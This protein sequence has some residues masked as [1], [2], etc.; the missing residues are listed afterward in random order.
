[1]EKG[2]G[3][4]SL[5]HCL[6][7]SWH[8]FRFLDATAVSTH[9]NEYFED[10]GINFDH[11]VFVIHCPLESWHVF[12]FFDDT[13][14][15]TCRPGSSPAG[16]NDGPGRPRH[17][18]ANMIQ[19]SFYW[20]VYCCAMNNIL[21]FF[22]NFFTLLRKHVREARSYYSTPPQHRKTLKLA[23]PLFCVIIAL[24]ITF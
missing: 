20:N 9:W 10:E 6:L 11:G 22:T 14:V 13:A 15:W 21:Y 7:E 3:H 16:D 12:G 2:G 24:Q 18:Y 5:G 4:G 1:M 17:Q 8:V 23:L 19:R